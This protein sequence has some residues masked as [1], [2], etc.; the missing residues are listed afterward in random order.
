MSVHAEVRPL[1]TGIGEMEPAV[2][3]AE[4]QPPAQAELGAAPELEVEL[5]I[6]AQVAVA[7]VGVGE[8]QPG[9]DEW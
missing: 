9:L 5:E 6:G 8:T 3:Q 4:G 1:D 2:L 7:D